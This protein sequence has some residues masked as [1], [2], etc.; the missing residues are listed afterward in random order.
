MR[1]LMIAGPKGGVGKTTTALN[2]AAAAA[3]SGRHAL[4]LD[5]D[6]FGGVA[7]LLAGGGRSHEAAGRWSAWTAA[8]PGVDV[9]AV[10]HGEPPTEE[11]WRAVL[12]YLSATGRGRYD[13]AFFDTVSSADLRS[14]VVLAACD[15]LLLVMRAEPLAYR[16]LPAVLRAVRDARLEGITPHF[17]GILL[18]QPPGEA[19]SALGEA[20][21]RGHFEHCLLPQGIPY[22]PAVSRAALQ[23][24]AVVLAS[25]A[26]AA[27]CQYTALAAALGLCVPHQRPRVA[28][29][30]DPRKRPSR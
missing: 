23:G 13:V 22:D 18:T 17:H 29:P 30:A 24:R 26:S 3:R 8:L 2:L 12:T 4:I 7:A 21:L 14:S 10:A 11:D 5:A 28:R 6:P 16:T 15:E 20:E 25:P 19:A 1:K 9:I 27:A